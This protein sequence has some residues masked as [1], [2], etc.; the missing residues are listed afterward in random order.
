MRYSLGAW[1]VMTVAAGF[2]LADPQEDGRTWPN[3]MYYHHH[4]S[5]AIAAGVDDDPEY[6]RKAAAPLIAMQGIL[7]NNCRPS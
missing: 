1:I 6:Y 3:D 2:A 4:P 5:K 7:C